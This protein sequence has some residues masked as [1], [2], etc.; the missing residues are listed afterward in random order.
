MVLVNI[1]GRMED[2][3]RDN[4]IMVINMVMVF[5]KKKLT[6]RP[7]KVNGTEAN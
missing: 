1:R 2:T 3:M 5:I 6:E 7:K 4:G